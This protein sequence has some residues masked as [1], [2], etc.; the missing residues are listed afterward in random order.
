MEYEELS[1]AKQELT[2]VETSLKISDE[3]LFGDGGLS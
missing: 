3:P 1:T 2:E